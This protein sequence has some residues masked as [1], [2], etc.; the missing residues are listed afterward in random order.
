M[1]TPWTSILSSGQDLISMVALRLISIA[2]TGQTALL[3]VM[4]LQAKLGPLTPIGL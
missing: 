1:A 4:A 3:K 2:I